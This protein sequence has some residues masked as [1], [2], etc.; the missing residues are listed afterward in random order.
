MK[1]EQK[2]SNSKCICECHNCRHRFAPCC[3]VCLT[4]QNEALESQVEVL[5]TKLI[6]I[7]S[8]SKKPSKTPK[9]RVSTTSS[10]NLQQVPDPK[11]GHLWQAKIEDKPDSNE[12]D[13][14]VC[15][16][17]ERRSSNGIDDSEYNEDNRSL[18]NTSENT[19]TSTSNSSSSS[20]EVSYSDSENSNESED[21]HSIDERTDEEDD[22]DEDDDDD[23]DDD[24]DY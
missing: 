22:D 17:E 12:C 2:A 4:S 18:T 16:C 19:S 20:S 6:N 21:D 14:N 23:D 7:K 9:Q 13:C 1:F 10:K 8:I 11:P 3:A 5:T 24:C 15:D